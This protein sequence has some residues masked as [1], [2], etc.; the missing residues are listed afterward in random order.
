M[1]NWITNIVHIEMKLD[2]EESNYEEQKAKLNKLYKKL[3]GKNQIF[4]FDAVIKSP[5]NKEVGSCSGKHK[6]GEVCWYE[7]NTENW[8]TKWNAADTKYLMDSYDDDSL[9]FEILVKFETAWN[10]PE[11][12]FKKL[13]KDFRVR[14]TWKDE[15]DD[16]WH[17][18][19]EVAYV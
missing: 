4:D 6:D 18:W 10:T 11:P 12:I 7:W 13:A 5:K 17:N 3:K 16:E 19:E 9:V 2:E 14:A 15:G 8:G 1:P